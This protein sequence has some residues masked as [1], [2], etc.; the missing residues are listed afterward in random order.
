MSLANAAKGLFRTLAP[1]RLQQTR[2]HLRGSAAQACT[3]CAGKRGRH[4]IDLDDQRAAIERPPWQTGRGLHLKGRTD[5][6]QGIASL[7]G[8]ECIFQH[9]RMERLA[10]AAVKLAASGLSVP[11]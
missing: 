10:E 3:G 2:Q 4:R 5:A 11:L 6:E 7:H 8:Q 9:S 1:Y